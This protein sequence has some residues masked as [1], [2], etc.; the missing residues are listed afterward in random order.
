MN[1]D[2]EI[3]NEGHEE[4]EDVLL[5]QRVPCPDGGCIG[6]IGAKGL[7]VECGREGGDPIGYRTAEAPGRDPCPDGNCIGL[8]D[9]DGVCRECGRAAESIDEPW[10]DDDEDDELD[11][12]DDIELDDNDED[13]GSLDSADRIPCPDGNC[14]G[15]MG[16]DNRCVECGRRKG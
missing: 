12:D 8:V 7:C 14:I 13:G 3:E 6:V 1:D 9:K 15:I 2:A 10:V 4:P 16:K 5:E 11:D